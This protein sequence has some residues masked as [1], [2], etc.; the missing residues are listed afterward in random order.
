VV[1]LHRDVEEIRQ[2]GGELHVIGNGTPNFIAGFREATRWDGPLY[3]DP[4]LAVYQAAQLKR[5]VTAT[6]NVRALAPT[7]GAFL[8]G[9]RQGLVRGDHWQQGGA[10]VIAPDGDVR[11]HHVSDHPADR[12]T[13]AE[14]VAA[15][16]TTR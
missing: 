7:V 9:N 15:L 13:T 4:S 14:I 1:Q 16:R 2:A 11:W 3:V 10:L 8:R 12:A 6:L 5:G